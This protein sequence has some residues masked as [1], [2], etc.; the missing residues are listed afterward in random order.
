MNPFSEKPIDLEASLTNWKDMY[1]KAYD[2]NETDPYTKT[3]I[4]LMNG[5]E[6]DANWFS[7]CFMRHTD[8]LALR[9]SLG[10]CRFVEKQQQQKLSMLKPVDETILETTIAYEQL[11]VDLT[12]ELCQARK[13]FSRKKSARFCPSGGF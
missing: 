6:Y 5:T 3:R 12:A 8:D 13:G 10:L 2:K 11:A 1:P 9:Q 4:I 7:H